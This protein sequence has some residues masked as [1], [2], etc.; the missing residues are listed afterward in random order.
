MA[1]L[2]FVC[3]NTGVR[4]QGWFADDGSAISEGTY[5]SVTCVAC[6]RVHLVNRLTG[7]TLGEDDKLGL[8]PN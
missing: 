3:P 1:T 8:Q 4:V 5:E 2:V 6:S 7:R